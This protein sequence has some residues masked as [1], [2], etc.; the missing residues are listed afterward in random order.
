MLAEE[1]TFPD[2]ESGD[3][4][5]LIAAVDEVERDEAVATCRRKDSAITQVASSNAGNVESSVE[6]SG[7]PA[8]PAS[9][10]DSSG[11]ISLPA[12]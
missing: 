6:G 4:D 12:Y 9:L 7:D 3:L 8:D 5:L 2:S 1:D 11:Y 10:E